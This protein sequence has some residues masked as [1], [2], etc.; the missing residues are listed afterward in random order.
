MLTR[1][2]L[3]EREE[4]V[5][6]PYAAKCGRSRGRRFPEPEHAYRT[7]FQ[8]DRDRVIHSA[9]FRRLEYKTQVF[10]NHEGDYYRTRLTHSMET[11]QIARSAARALAL[12]E[13]LCEVLAL[14]HDLGHTP[15]GHS[16]QD[17]LNECM[18]DHGG[19]EHNVQSLRVVEVLETRYPQFA[20][21][22]LTWETRESMRKHTVRPG[23]PVEAEYEPTWQTLLENQLVDV[24]DS[25]AYDA[26]DL[27][28]GL[29]AGLIDDPALRGV[30]LWC[31]ASAAVES[32]TPQAT[33][34]QRLRQA[35]RRIIDTEVTD[36]IT[37]TDRN[38][39]RLG[40]RTVEDVR[41]CSE[42][43]VGFS[44]ET[45]ARKRELQGFLHAHV[46]RHHRVVVMSEKAKRFIRSLF[47]AYVSNLDQL[48]PRF[49]DWAK[50]VGV[51]RAV[52]DY[53]AGMTDRYAQDEVRRLFYPFETV[54]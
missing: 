31:E 50:E 18:K 54:L 27:D 44:P 42:R 48:P 21:L 4:K 37:T 38:L 36:L 32:A 14:A 9:A 23:K 10:L 28:D 25:I 17:A 29:K 22:N 33:S 11:A 16:G 52:A 20:G 24:A 8:R 19:F 12:N 35:V 34:E 46:Y 7:A 1:Q 5:L 30:R 40:I 41:R 3:E 26:H 6:A 15:F 45:E 47:D 43:V 13:D 49:R 53:I 2:Q 39:A 51:H